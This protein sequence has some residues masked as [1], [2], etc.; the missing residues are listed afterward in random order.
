MAGWKFLAERLDVSLWD[1]FAE[2][3]CLARRTEINMTG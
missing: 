1:V 3:F 2:F